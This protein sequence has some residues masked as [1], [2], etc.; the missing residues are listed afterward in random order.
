M[1][2]SY[3]PLEDWSKRDDPKP[4]EKLKSWPENIPETAVEALPLFANVV[5]D[6]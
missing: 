6:M 2:N 3:S 1:S 4:I 5:M